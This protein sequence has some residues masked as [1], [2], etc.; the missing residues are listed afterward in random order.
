MTFPTFS[1]LGDSFLLMDFGNE[2]QKKITHKIVRLTNYWRKFPIKGVLNIVPAACSI[3]ILY[4]P[5]QWTCQTFKKSSHQKLMELIL[6]D[7][8][9]SQKMSFSLP[10]VA[11]IPVVYGGDFGQDFAEL[12]RILNISHE[13]LIE[14][15]SQQIY[16]VYMIGFAPGFPYLGPLDSRLRVPRKST[17]RLK[18]P[19]GSVAIAQ[20]MT[21]IYPG[22]YPGG[23]HLIGRT[24][25]TMFDAFNG[26]GATLNIG[27]QVRFTVISKQEFGEYQN[28]AE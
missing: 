12:A 19:K 8:S 22:E 11:N 25:M 6:R 10:R 23:W 16:T 21:G 7:L 17:P 26:L 28:K 5:I 13:E 9:V 1:L 18:V 27:D 2:P 15:H 24:P 3:G 4:D 14:I 20:Q